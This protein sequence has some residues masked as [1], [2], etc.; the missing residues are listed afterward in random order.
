M[1]ILEELEIDIVK[2][3][4]QNCD[5]KFTAIGRVTTTSAN[6]LDSY[7]SEMIKPETGTI[8]LNMKDIT[9]LTSA[10]IRV[11]LKTFKESKKEGIKFFIENPSENVKNVLGLSALQQ[12]LIR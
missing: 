1:G 8:I 4:E 2:S 10:G 9:L 3:G 12:M 7:L 6:K 11:I 5:V